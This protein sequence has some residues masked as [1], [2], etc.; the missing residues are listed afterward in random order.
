[1]E[2][3]RAANR[4]LR[5]QRLVLFL[6]QRLRHLPHGRRSRGSRPLR[7]FP[8]RLLLRTD[9]RKF[10][11][12]HLRLYLCQRLFFRGEALHPALIRG[13]ERE[14][15]RRRRL[16]E[17][18][19]DEAVEAAVGQMHAQEQCVRLRVEILSEI[20][21]CR[22]IHQDRPTDVHD[23]LWLLR[24]GALLLFHGLQR[25]H[26]VLLLE[27]VAAQGRQRVQ[28]LFFH[29]LIDIEFQRPLTTEALQMFGKFHLDAIALHDAANGGFPAEQEI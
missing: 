21:P 10:F 18:L 28:N 25:P 6:Y 29:P 12:L 7:Q 24:C 15:Q 9:G 23:I 13:R 27:M 4:L 14:E 11:F 17:V 1:M 8:K 2:E 19:L 16:G 5:E 22:N 26:D 20:A 3:R